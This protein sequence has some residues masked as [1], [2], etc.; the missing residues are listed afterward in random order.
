MPFQC[1]CALIILTILSDG[2]FDYVVPKARLS[3]YLKYAINC[4]D[5]ACTKAGLR[6]AKTI[7]SVPAAISVPV[8]ENKLSV[9]L[10]SALGIKFSKGPSFEN[11]H[12][13][14]G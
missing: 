11:F 13:G 14:C 9:D 4:L 2:P 3:K 10:R 8:Q 1:L 12:L 5:L 6:A 7:A